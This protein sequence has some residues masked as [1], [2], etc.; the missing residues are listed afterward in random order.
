MEVS[1]KCSI[2]PFFSGGL[3]EE[4][5]RLPFMLAGISVESV[6]GLL[7]AGHFSLW[8]NYVPKETL[9]FFEK[10]NVAL[11]HRFTSAYGMGKDEEDSKE[12]LH[13]A[14]ACLRVVKATRTPFSA[15]QYR[16]TTDAAIDVFSF[17]PP[18]NT[19]TMNLPRSEILNQI[20]LRDL[21]TTPHSF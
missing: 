7:T 18:A 20:T 11:V 15:V 9:A 14:F 16:T 5:I 12:L 13:K 21:E 1:E 3:D 17:V 2:T 8:S 6:K 19:L 10:T 4:N